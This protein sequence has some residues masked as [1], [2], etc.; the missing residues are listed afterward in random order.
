MTGF[1]SR[2]LPDAL[3][4][5]DDLAFFL[6]VDG[7]IL[8]FSERPETVVIPPSL[9]SLL[10]ALHQ[11]FCGA[12]AL[13]T[14]RDAAFIDQVFPFELPLSAEHGCRIRYEIG[15]PITDLVPR[16]D[17]EGIS[18]A[19][20]A[21]L[22]GIPGA[23]P[24]IRDFARIFH[25]RGA[26][27]P[28]KECREH[29]TKL[30]QEIVDEYNA[31]HFRNDHLHLTHGAMVLEVGPAG[32]DKGCAI[33]AFMNNPRFQGRRPVFIGDS[34]HSDGFGMRAVRQMGGIAIGVGPAM[35]TEEGSSL[36][37]FWLPDPG[38]V[39]DFLGWF[40]KEVS[41]ESRCDFQK[42]YDLGPT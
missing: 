7:T 21:A 37:D 40:Q 25:W 3:S 20:Y 9:P 14:A 17:F 6:D 2:C 13:V 16:P 26:E 41:Q 22:Q 35:G 30:G 5:R 15:G 12:L 39:R 1:S 4:G 27:I 29:F 34:P 33:Q 36:C 31:S 38:A 23:R 24:E 8:D 28:E 10:K 11:R 19:F 42:T 32:S 18:S